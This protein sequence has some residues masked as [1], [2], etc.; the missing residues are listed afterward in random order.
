MWTLAFIPVTNTLPIPSL[1]V[2][3]FKK[4]NTALGTAVE[5]LETTAIEG[6]VIRMLGPAT[7]LVQQL[8]HGTNEGFLIEEVQIIPD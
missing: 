7:F 4:L 1:G 3:L 2:R 8:H 6:V 5:E